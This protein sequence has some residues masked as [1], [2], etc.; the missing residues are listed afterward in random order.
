MGNEYLRFCDTCGAPMDTG[1][2][3]DGEYACCRECA[4]EL[5]NGDE[6]ELDDLLSRYEYDDFYYTEWYDVRHDPPVSSPEHFNIIFGEFINTGD[7]DAYGRPIIAVKNV[8][9]VKSGLTDIECYDWYSTSAF[10]TKHSVSTKLCC[11][12]MWNFCRTLIFSD[13]ETLK[14]VQSECHNDTF[15][16]LRLATSDELIKYY[17]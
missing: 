2:Y 9:D 11:T 1:F 13:Q 4:I 3:L 12:D 15:W 10:Y 6:K 5:C 7:E 14:R 17:Q 16:E 8:T